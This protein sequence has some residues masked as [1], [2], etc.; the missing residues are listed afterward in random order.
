LVSIT[1]LNRLAGEQHRL[2]Q[3]LPAGFLADD[4]KVR[5]DVAAD[6]ADGMAFE[7]LHVVL[8]AGG[9]ELLAA[10]RVSLAGRESGNAGQLLRIETAGRRERS[11]GPFLQD[12]IRTV[13]QQAGRVGD[14]RLRKL[15]PGMSV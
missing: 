10:R 5:A 15:L 9:N 7:A 6:A 4:R 14:E 11:Q 2:Q 1:Q 12:L 13:A 3:V 8:D